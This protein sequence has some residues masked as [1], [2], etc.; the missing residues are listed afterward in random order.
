MKIV[1]LIIGR[2][3]NTLSDKNILP[4]LGKPLLQWGALAAKNSS[5]INYHYISSD[6]DKILDAGEAVG[7]VSIRRPDYLSLPTAQS[8]DVVKHALSSIEK[9]I[10][11][12]DVMVVIHANVGTISTKM[13]DEC[14]SLL[15]SNN[16]SSVIPSHYKYEYH[17]QRAKRIL[18]DGTLDNYVDNGGK[19]VPANRQ[20]LDQ[21]VFFDH[22]FWV[23]H[24]ERGIKGENGQYPWPVMG[25]K[26]FPYMTEGC[27][28]VHDFEDL[29]KTEQWLV[30]NSISYE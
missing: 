3:N 4:V 1:S 20:E 25:N 5:Y 15:Q 26:I 14:I 29:K 12:V 17:P 8:S 30:E 19:Y 22:S 27:F 9:D 16:Y 2:G 10:G 21:C 6:D 18:E 7:F 28:D 24:V 11:E 13:I 23:L